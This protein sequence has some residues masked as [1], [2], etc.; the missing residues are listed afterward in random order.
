[1]KEYVAEAIPIKKEVINTQ[2]A[3]ARFAEYGMDDKAALFRYRRASKVNIYSI[4][5]FR[6]YYYGY[7]VAN[8]SYLK[9]FALEVYEDGF[10]LQF[11]KRE[12][13]KVIPK[14]SFPSNNVFVRYTPFGGSIFSSSV[15]RFRVGIPS[16][17][18][19]ACP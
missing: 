4:G 2:E 13:P 18:P 14:I 3:I 19:M 9:W 6:D 8:T 1:M 7:M 12:N 10:M 17:L 15:I 11:P 16:F 5:G